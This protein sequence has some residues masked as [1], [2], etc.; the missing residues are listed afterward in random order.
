MFY[1]EDGVMTGNLDGVM[2]GNLDALGIFIHGGNTKISRHI[3]HKSF[4]V[5]W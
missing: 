1:Y 2:T 4:G 5:E 3:I